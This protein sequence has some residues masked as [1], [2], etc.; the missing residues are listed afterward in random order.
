[1][2]NSAISR[3]SAY[4]VVFD[5]PFLYFICKIIAFKVLQIIFPRLVVCVVF[6]ILAYALNKS[7]VDI[8]CVLSTILHSY[9]NNTI[10]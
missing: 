3:P 2:L 1:M 10:F 9:L 5:R 7:F 4:V 8:L 6:V